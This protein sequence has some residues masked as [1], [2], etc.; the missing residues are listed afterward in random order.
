MHEHLLDS[1]PTLAVIIRIK[2]NQQVG[3]IFTLLRL[4]LRLS[5][6]WVNFFGFWLWRTQK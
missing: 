2:E 1:I 5:G 6:F 4:R 3:S